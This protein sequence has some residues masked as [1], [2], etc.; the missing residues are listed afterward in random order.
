MNKLLFIIG[1]SDDEQV[2]A[3]VSH[4]SNI[5]VVYFNKETQD[6][7]T[8]SHSPL[9]NC[10]E[11]YCCD[12]LLLPDAV[13]WRSLDYD[14]FE[15]DKD[16]SNGDAYIELFTNAFSDAL[17][18]NPPQAYREHQT[19]IKQ[20]QTVLSNDVLMP[21]T[22]MTNDVDDALH[23]F[24]R[25]KPIALKP[26]A[27]GA[28]T[29]KITKK[30]QLRQYFEEH[31]HPVCLQEFI[32]GPSIRTFVIGDK[33]Y[34]TI[35]YADGPDFRIDDNASYLPVSIPRGLENTAIQITKELG[36]HWTAIDWICRDDKYY[37]LEANFSPMFACHEEL[38]NQPISQEIA[39]YIL[40]T[41]EL[42]SFSQFK[43]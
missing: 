37:F 14:I 10:T 30:K 6:D 43:P 2:V 20:I 25:N 32:E 13:F 22:L 18:L 39:N 33:V 9:S 19:K 27:G 8:I 23:F 38:T 1:E 5:D 17:W 16:P 29:L 24:K 26:I 7:F 34:S 28:Y 42:V 35:I 31:S 21:K 15:Y 4:L 41:I 3:L 36:M 40:D 11:V 12:Q